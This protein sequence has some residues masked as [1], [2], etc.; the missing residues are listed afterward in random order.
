M[1]RLRVLS[2]LLLLLPFLLVVQF[3]SPLH[4]HLL[5]SVANLRCGWEFA[6]LCPGGRTLGWRC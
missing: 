3:G 6:W 2:A 5:V 4:L 1:H